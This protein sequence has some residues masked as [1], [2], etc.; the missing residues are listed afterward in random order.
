MHYYREL[1]Y[2][3]RR[4]LRGRYRAAW[5]AAMLGLT[6]R[7]AAWLCPA[8]L[9]AV[10]IRRG[11]LRP[12]AL[13]TSPHW[14]LAAALWEA[15][16]FCIRMPVQCGIRSWFTGLTELE[17]PGQERCFFRTAGAYFRGVYFFGM[18]ALLRFLAAA[19]LAGACV[20]TVLALRQ[21][22]GREEGVLWLFAAVQGAAAAFW[23]ACWYVRFCVSLSAV[24]YLFLENPRRGVFRT[25]RLSRRMMAG[26]HGRFW[27]IVLPYAAIPGIAPLLLPR[28][29]TEIT[30]F[31]QL[32]MREYAQLHGG[33]SYA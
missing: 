15:A 11:A 33:E 17:V 8:V 25:I 21:S 27:S 12:E 32:R 18:T 6:V 13:F 4:A 5:A 23:A 3:S 20:L 7:L 28:L 31:L 24:P 9:A 30:L 26:Y 29:M 14:L 1:H 16:A 2:F 10:L 19:P 22:I